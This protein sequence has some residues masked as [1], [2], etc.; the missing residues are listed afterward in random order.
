MRKILALNLNVRSII[1]VINSRASA[2][3]RYIVEVMKYVEETLEE[4]HIGAGVAV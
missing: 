4:M 3:I 2:E 1:S